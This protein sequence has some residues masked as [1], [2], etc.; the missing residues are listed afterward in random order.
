M[1]ASM[2]SS[3]R[4]VLQVTKSTAV[5][6]MQQMMSDPKGTVLRGLSAARSAPREW[7]MIWLAGSPVMFCCVM[8]KSLRNKVLKALA[9]AKTSLEDFEESDDET[10]AELAEIT[11][12]LPAALS[13]PGLNFVVLAFLFL[14]R[15]GYVLSAV[16]PAMFIASSSSLFSRGLLL[17]ATYQRTAANPLLLS[18][19]CTHFIKIGAAL[20]AIIMCFTAYPCYRRFRHQLYID[21]RNDVLREIAESRR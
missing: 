10:D 17:A 6:L 5:W 7:Q 2:T 15:F 16:L 18:E 4:T 9:V 3:C 14:A 21:A 13:I 11:L 8:I 19:T 12:F 20:D 1:E